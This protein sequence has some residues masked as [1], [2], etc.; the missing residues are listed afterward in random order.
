MYWCWSQSPLRLRSHSPCYNRDRPARFPFHTR[1][2]LNP[3]SRYPHR[4]TRYRRPRPRI[5]YPLRSNLTEEE[6][7]QSL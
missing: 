6:V 1:P 2:R 4:S 3:R 5:R 7:E